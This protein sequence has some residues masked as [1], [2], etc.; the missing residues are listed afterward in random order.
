M[1]RT[2]VALILI[3]LVAVPVVADYSNVGDLMQFGVSA[4][5]TGLGG[6]FFPL[7]DDATA[8]FYNPAGLGWV[9]RISLTSYVSRRFDAITYG[10]VGIT[11]PYIG[12]VL[13]RLDSGLIP[14]PAGGF[15]YVSQGGVIGVG[16]A[17]GPVGIGARFKLITIYSPYAAVG[18]AIDPALLVVTDVVRVGIVVNNAYSR[19]VVLPDATTEAWPL[20]VD[21]GVALRAGTGNRVNWDATF[22]ASDLFTA[23]MRIA[24]GV[25]VWVG[26]LGIRTG[27]NTS[28]LSL[29][30]SVRFPSMRI[31][32]AYTEH[33]H[34]GGSYDASVTFNF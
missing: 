12:A 32:F 20:T 24:A 29:G 33:A 18:W 26:G 25:E 7:A 27:W 1:R 13:M 10:A 15:S 9:N 22:T 11:L 19:P 3:A 17:L 2:T 6:A 16:V 23:A 8:A 5:A 28:G 21:A 34:L 4:R 14:T 31:D 30:L